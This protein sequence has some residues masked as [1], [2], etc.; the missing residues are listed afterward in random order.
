MSKHIRFNEDALSSSAMVD[1]IPINV[2]ESINADDPFS[3]AALYV[4][5]VSSFNHQEF[6][7]VLSVYFKSRQGKNRTLEWIKS[8]E[9]LVFPFL[10]F[11]HS[12]LY[13]CPIVT[14]YDAYYVSDELLSKMHT[15]LHSYLDQ[16]Q[17]SKDYADTTMDKRVIFLKLY[18]KWFYLYSDESKAT[19]D[20]YDRAMDVLLNTIQSYRA[21]SS[22][23]INT[24]TIEDLTNNLQWPVNG[25]QGIRDRLT[26]FNKSFIE[27]FDIFNPFARERY[28][29][30]MGYLFVSLYTYAVQGRIGGLQSMTKA[31]GAQLKADSK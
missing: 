20:T 31:N 7:D 11:F 28:S 24:D 19:R 9:N 23:A 2:V 16:Y 18:F 3:T 22:S 14:I 13:K 6:I 1:E 27:D 12:H 25:L 8:L 26:I 15:L 10:S 21:K 5:N 30:Y 17:Q 29:D 4:S